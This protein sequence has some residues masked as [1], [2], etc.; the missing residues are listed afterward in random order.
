MLTNEMGITPECKRYVFANKNG[1]AIKNLYKGFK[2]ACKKAGYPD[3]RWHNLRHTNASWLLQGGTGLTVVKEVLGHK[4]INTT[5]R[6]AHLDID[7]QLNAMNKSLKTHTSHNYDISKP[8]TL[9]NPTEMLV[10]VDGEYLNSLFDELTEFEAQLK[11]FADEIMAEL[12]PQPLRVEGGA[13]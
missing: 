12:A 3:V 5:L 2:L 11:P 7:T 9:L 6:Y 10:D 4:N 1:D 13:L 8:S